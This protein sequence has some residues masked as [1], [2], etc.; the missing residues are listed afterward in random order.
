MSRRSRKYVENAPFYDSRDG[1]RGIVPRLLPVQVITGLAQ[2]GGQSGR[3]QSLLRTLQGIFCHTFPGPAKIQKF[4]DP[5]IDDA[6]AHKYETVLKFYLKTILPDGLVLNHPLL[7]R[8]IHDLAIP[9][10]HTFGI[11]EFYQICLPAVKYLKN[12]ESGIGNFPYLAHRQRLGDRLHAGFYG[13]PLQK[14]GSQ[15][16][17]CQG[18]QNISLNAASHSIRQYNNLRIVRLKDLHL[19]STEFFMMLVQA[20]PGYIYTYTHINLPLQTELNPSVLTGSLWSPQSSLPEGRR[21]PAPPSSA[22][23]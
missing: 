3:R 23:Q 7:I 13:C 1:N 17:G 4:S 2:H 11:I 22:C 21:F 6:I 9:H 14:H 5:R 10:K 19:V 16:L 8:I 18:G 15:D 12:A 20:F